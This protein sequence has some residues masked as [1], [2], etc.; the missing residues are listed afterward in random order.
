MAEQESRVAK[1]KAEAEAKGGGARKPEPG[2]NQ[3]G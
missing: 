1:Q 2:L 3:D